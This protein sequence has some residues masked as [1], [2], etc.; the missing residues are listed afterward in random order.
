MA[1]RQLI[2]HVGLPKTGTTS[3]QRSV[4]PQLESYL[5]GTEPGGRDKNLASELLTLYQGKSGHPNF[6]SSVW[7]ESVR[8]WWASVQAV[9][10]TTTFISLEGLF[11][12]FDPLSAHPWPLMGDGS[13]Y[14]SSRIGRHPIIDFASSLANE[15]SPAQLKL[16]L[17]IRNQGDFVASHYSQLSYR[18]VGPSQ[19]D[20]NRKLERLLEAPDPFFDW[21]TTI[22][23]LQQI[24]GEENLLCP[25]FEDGLDIVAESIIRFVEPAANAVNPNRSNVR[26]SSD[27]WKLDAAPSSSVRSTVRKLWPLDRAPRLRNLMASSG[28]MVMR[29]LPDVSKGSDNRIRLNAQLRQ[30]L[31]SSFRSSNEQLSAL[32]H[33]NL[34]DLG[35]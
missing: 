12:W 29:A 20:F 25:I 27:G 28:G 2:L 7:R 10:P 4:F 31:Q 22:G 18:M 19:N 5:G 17:T 1:E 6:H 32:L 26:S 13:S 30:E 24:V 9:L 15:V 14:R 21:Y 34:F 8:N 23:A 33:R 3:L 11:R 35:Y 16:V